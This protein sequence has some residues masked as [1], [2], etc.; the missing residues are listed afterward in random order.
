MAK[1][2]ILSRSTRKQ[3]DELFQA[4]QF[5]D[6][7]AL[8]EE[9]CKKDRLDVDAHVMQAI[10]HIQLEDFLGAEEICKQAIKLNQDHPLDHHA[11]GTVYD[12]TGRPADVRRVSRS[13]PG[14]CGAGK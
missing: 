9:I 3:A 10:C 7:A 5:A 13:R 11:L 2:N 4:Q 8:Y 12:R 14:S 6:A 1:K